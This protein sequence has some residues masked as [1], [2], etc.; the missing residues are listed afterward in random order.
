MRELISSRRNPAVIKLCGL[1]EKKNREAERLFRFDGIKLYL[2]AASAGVGME[3]I[4]LRQSSAAGIYERISAA[5][6]PIP[7]EGRGQV[8][9]LAD[10]LFDA[11][12][13][14]KSPEG[15]ITA[16]KYIDKFHKTV[17]ID[18]NSNPPSDILSLCGERI[19]MLED[20]R[21]PGN[22]GTILR[23]AGA[24]GFG[25]VC[26]AGECADIYSPKTLRASMGA[27]FK[28]R[29]LSCRDGESLARALRAGGRRVLAAALDPGAVSLGK[30]SLSRGDCVVI[31][32]EGHGL[33]RC[34]RAACEASVM[35]PMAEGF[36]SLNASVAAAIFMW[37]AAR[38]DGEYGRVDFDRSLGSEKNI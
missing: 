38:G 8:C 18:N 5:G 36:E 12:S 9:L 32:N 28:V 34:L 16:A 17:K 3:Q 10:S 2:E 33:S 23:T 4:F 26:L 30:V 6:A 1:A 35:I 31:G 20:I 15:I 29:T 21:D 19:I 22:L 7:G 37:E 25:T 24:L 11:V 14:E 13:E 27:I